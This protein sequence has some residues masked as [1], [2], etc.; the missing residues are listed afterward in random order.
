MHPG[1]LWGGGEAV[2]TLG[3]SF[4]VCSCQGYHALV[5]LYKEGRG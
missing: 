3:G 2:L 1:Q 5:N 4:T